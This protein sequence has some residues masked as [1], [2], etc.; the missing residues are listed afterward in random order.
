MKMEELLRGFIKL[1]IG[2]VAAQV[3]MAGAL[4]APDSGTKAAEAAAKSEKADTAAA[5]IVAPIDEAST[6]V[7]SVN[8]TPERTFD[9]GRAVQV[10]TAQDIWRK[11]ARTLPELLV[12]EAGIFVQQTNYGGGSPIIRGL[13]GKQIVILI[14]G[15]R[16]NNATFRFGP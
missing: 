5:Q 9:T 10:I 2:S 6:L 13:M 11:N 7:Y 12:D 14:D 8:R 15:V 3:G 1:V 16:L 4:A